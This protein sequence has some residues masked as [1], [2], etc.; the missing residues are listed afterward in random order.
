MLTAGLINLASQSLYNSAYSSFIKTTEEISNTISRQLSATNETIE[1]I[2]A[3]FESSKYVDKQE[4]KNFTS[5][6]LDRHSFID[7]IYYIQHV[8][9]EEKVVYEEKLT[10]ELKFPFKIHETVDSIEINNIQKK[11]YFPVKYIE[12]YTR[13][14]EHHHGYDISEQS[15]S[16]LR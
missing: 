14:T 8:T 16:T 7:S 6:F 11:Q 5:G 13:A 12:P 15:S 3:F 1:G 9:E 4:F 2:T 10:E